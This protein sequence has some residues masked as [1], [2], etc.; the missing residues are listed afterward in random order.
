ML[1]AGSV[2]GPRVTLLL[3]LMAFLVSLRIFIT[4]PQTRSLKTLNTDKH[5]AFLHLTAHHTT[6]LVFLW[7]NVVVR[8]AAV[9]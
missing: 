6:L 9:W 8:E 4:W 2:S 7:Q 1:A 5:A 3:I